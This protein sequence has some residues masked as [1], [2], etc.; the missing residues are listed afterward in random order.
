[1]SYGANNNIVFAIRWYFIG[2]FNSIDLFVREFGFNSIL[3]GIIYIFSL[4][5]LMLI[6]GLPFSYYSTFV[7]EQKYNFNKSTRSLFFTDTIKTIGLS[8]LIGVPILYGILWFF[9]STGDYG[10]VL[11]WGFLVSVQ[12]ILVYLA[13]TLIMPL[14]NKFEPLAAGELKTAIQTYAKNHNFGLKEIFT[15]DGSK[16][17]A[18]SN[19]YFTGFGKQ[20]RIVLFDTLIEKHSTDELLVILAHEMGH[21]KKKHIH[22]T[23]LLSIF[24]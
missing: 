10:W 3:T 23:L 15:M 20:R 16:R 11:V 17:S 24:E 14:F 9:E 13:P 1:M 8:V 7:I 22:K 21:F 12:F 5:G 6:I 4:G 19:A 2:G 18:K